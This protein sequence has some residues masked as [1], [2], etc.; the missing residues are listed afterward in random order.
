M[1]TH[2]HGP[3]QILWEGKWIFLSHLI[4]EGQE[5]CLVGVSS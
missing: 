5:E 1:G 2:P 3:S 4:K